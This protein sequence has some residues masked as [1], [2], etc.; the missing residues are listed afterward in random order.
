MTLFLIVALGVPF[1]YIAY[2]A[3][4]DYQDSRRQEDLARWATITLDE[5]LPYPVGSM[6]IE[7]DP[8]FQEESMSYS[9]PHRG[10][11]RVVAMITRLA[12]E[13][14]ALAALASA[15]QQGEDGKWRANGKFV[16]KAAVQANME[17][18]AESQAVIASINGKLRDLGV[19]P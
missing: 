19:R 10:S 17:A 14:A 15:M 12:K 5:P 18:R 9:P 2:E 6:P 1:A 7:V 3:V 4:S 13:R 16:A 8:T 11:K